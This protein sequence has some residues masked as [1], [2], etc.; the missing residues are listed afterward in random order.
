MGTTKEGPLPPKRDA[1]RQ[2][3]GSHLSMTCGA[4]LSYGLYPLCMFSLGQQT[5]S[6]AVLMH[7]KKK[8]RLREI[9]QASRVHSE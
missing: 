6:E 8:Q 9:S 1:R 3:S 4:P 7:P 2:S 5:L